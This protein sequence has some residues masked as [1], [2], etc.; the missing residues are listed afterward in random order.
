M[1]V[2]DIAMSPGIPRIRWAAGVSS[3]SLLTAVRYPRDCWLVGELAP[4]VAASPT[5]GQVTTHL[6]T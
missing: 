4:F 2:V 3:I 1:N 5:T 6:P